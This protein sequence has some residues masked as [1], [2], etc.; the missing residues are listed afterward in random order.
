MMFMSM[1][2]DYVSELWPPT[3]L[4][5]IPHGKYENEEHGGMMSTEE[6]FLY[7]YTRSLWQSY[8][9]NHLVA[10]NNTGEKNAEFGLS[11]YL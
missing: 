7:S 3:S 1:G 4:L 2:R 5:F 10:S 9:H 8:Q 6:N 11:K